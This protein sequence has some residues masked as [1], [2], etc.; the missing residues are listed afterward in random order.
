MLAG[1]LTVCAI[2]GTT[3]LAIKIG[4]NAGLPPLLFA[5]VR[6]LIAGL[7]TL[8]WL[9]LR[10]TP[11]PAS[12]RAYGHMVLVGL[13]NIAIAFAGLF[14]AEQYLPSSLAAICT[15]SAPVLT[16]LMVRRSGERISRW[17]LAGLAGGLAGVMLALAPGLRAE[18]SSVSLLG[19]GTI[20]LGETGVAWGTVHA[21]RVMASGVP[22][23]LFAAWQMLFGGLMLLAASLLFET[24]RYAEIVP[25]PAAVGALL[26]LAIPGSV[27][28]RS[29]LFWL[30]DRTGPLF[31]STW[32]YI[33]PI[34]ATLAGALVLAEPIGWQTLVGL[35]L[36]LSAAAMTNETIRSLLWRRIQPLAGQGD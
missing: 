36:V 33:S 15:A 17:Q 1:Y 26:Y 2:F 32:T 30:V 27:I 25:S 3:F 13:T 28:A 18:G 24:G 29:L 31:P 14:W 10:G 7:I 20:L 5:G 9:R 12:R 34:L 4:L 8:A 35:F 19:V 6:F 21:R 16:A 23:V 22:P 11:M